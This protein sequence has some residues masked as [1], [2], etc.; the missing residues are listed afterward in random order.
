MDNKSGEYTE[1]Q[2]KIMQR[3]CR[4]L[5]C[6]SDPS[7]SVLVETAGRGLDRLVFRIFYGD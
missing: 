6:G 1:F 3:F 2:M 5:C 4:Y 7:I